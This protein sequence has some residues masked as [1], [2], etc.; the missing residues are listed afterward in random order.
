MHN[1]KPGLPTWPVFSPFVTFNGIKVKGKVGPVHHEDA[2]GSGDKD[3]RIL[4]PGARWR[5]D[6]SGKKPRYPLR[7]KKSGP[8]PGLDAVEKRKIP[9]PCRESN[10]FLGRWLVDEKIKVW[11]LWT[12]SWMKIIFWDAPTCSPLKVNRRFGGTCLQIQNRRISQEKRNSVNQFL[13]VSRWFLASI[14]EPWR[15]RREVHQCPSW[16]VK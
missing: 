11:K 13:H 15:W 4:N 1:Q 3:P 10:K 7:K 9:C 12:R 6:L 2:C 16:P 14:L 8:G 5:W